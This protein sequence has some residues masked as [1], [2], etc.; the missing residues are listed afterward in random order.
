VDFETS[1]ARA[2]TKMRVT[3]QKLDGVEY[4]LNSLARKLTDA[5]R[6]TVYR[7]E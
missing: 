6:E 7:R 1:I 3:W 5:F 2:T 4:P